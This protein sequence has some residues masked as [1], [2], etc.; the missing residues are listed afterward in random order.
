MTST[1]A[2]MSSGSTIDAQSSHF[3]ERLSY[4]HFEQLR[5]SGEKSPPLQ[6]SRACRSSAY[7]DLIHAAILAAYSDP[8][9]RIGAAVVA[10]ALKDACSAQP[11][12]ARNAS[13]WLKKRGKTWM[14]TLNLEPEHIKEHI[15]GNQA[16]TGQLA[17]R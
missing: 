3:E 13:R 11:G 12:I 10:L 2:D 5:S 7:T 9:E 16:K 15:H 6:T 1:E 17:D 14:E 8:Y 4:R